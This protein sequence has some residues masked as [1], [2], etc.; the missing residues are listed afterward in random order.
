MGLGLEVLMSERESCL[1]KVTMDIC[2]QSS[3]GESPECLRGTRFL[4]GDVENYLKETPSRS[5]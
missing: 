5:F 1:M 4:G 3:K 2:K